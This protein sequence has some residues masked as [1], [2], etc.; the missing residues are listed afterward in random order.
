MKHTNFY[1]LVQGIQDLEIKELTEAVKAH[2][3]VYEWQE[4]E[5]KPIV[6]ANPYSCEPQP[7]DIKIT[8]VYL[9]DDSLC[10]EGVDNQDNVSVEFCITDIFVGQISFIIDYIPEISSCNNITTNSYD[11]LIF[12]RFQ[13]IDQL[14]KRL[15]V[16]GLKVLS[17]NP[18][19]MENLDDPETG[20]KQPDYSLLVDLDSE[21]EGE[22]A[23]VT[24]FY[25]TDREGNIVITETA[26][27][28]E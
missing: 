16:I 8:R 28:W 19:D 20:F 21:K 22:Y 2:G 7:V 11:Q 27:R 24:L 14:R 12:S 15:E 4:D 1:A 5:E 10:I 6:A 17:I 13:S 9:Q 25:Y 3:G 23:H 18:E 26:F